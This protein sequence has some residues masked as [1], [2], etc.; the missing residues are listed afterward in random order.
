M[1]KAARENI[2]GLPDCPPHLSEPAYANLAFFPNCHVCIELSLL[3]SFISLR[4]TVL[5]QVQR[6]NCPVG[7]QRTILPRM[8]QGPV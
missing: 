3:N 7:V 4:I 2:E 5:P 6:A 8:R 1:W